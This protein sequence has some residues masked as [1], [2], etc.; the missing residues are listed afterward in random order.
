M[1]DERRLD[2]LRGLDSGGR[3]LS[4]VVG[5]FVRDTP[6]TMQALEE[7]GRARDGPGTMQLAHRLRG[8]AGMLGA[9][10]LA[11]LCATLE[12]RANAGLLDGALDLLADIRAELDRAAAALGAA[13]AP[14][15]PQ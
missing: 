10:S 11:A 3:L 5:T 12:E 13:I 1:L 2:V 8:M 9:E 4:R 6:T 7:A 14:P 15:Q